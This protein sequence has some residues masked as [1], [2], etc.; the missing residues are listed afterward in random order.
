LRYQDGSASTTDRELGFIETLQKELPLMELVS[1]N[2]YAGASTESAYKTSANLLLQLKRLD[3]IFCPNEST[4]TGMLRALEDAHR[5]GQVKL[6]GFDSSDKLR[7]A[8]MQGELQA[9]MLQNP[10]A[11]GEL[12]VQAAVDKLDNKPVVAR[13]DTGVRLATRANLNQP[14]VT[15]LS[16]PDVS[17]QF[18]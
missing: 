13:I 5:V 8:L 7:T 1:S 2:Q 16:A 9:L 15:E 6:V 18:K 4:T 3:A 11:M 14:A 17:S 10:F 12:G